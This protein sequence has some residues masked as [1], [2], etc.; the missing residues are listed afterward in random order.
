M[1][2]GGLRNAVLVEAVLVEEGGGG[3]GGEAQEPAAVLLAGRRPAVAGQGAGEQRQ[4]QLVAPLLDEAGCPR[5]F[6]PGGADLADEQPQPLGQDRSVEVGVE[7]QVDGGGALVGGQLDQRSG[8]DVQH[9][10]GGVAGE[11]G[12]GGVARQ[13][14]QLEGR[15]RV[16]PGCRDEDVLDVQVPVSAPDER[17]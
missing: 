9:E 1:L 5:P 14:D 11:H 17:G 15:A 16:L 13:V 4:R 8:E 7:Q 12:I 2:L 10:M 6:F 3:V